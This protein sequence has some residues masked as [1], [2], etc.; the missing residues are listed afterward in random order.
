MVSTR[1]SRRSNPEP[2]QEVTAP[3]GRNTRGKKLKTKNTGTGLSISVDASSKTNI[4][5]DVDE[6]IHDPPEEE[7][8]EPEVEKES[9]DDDD[10][11]VV[12]EVK[13]VAARRDALEQLNDEETKGLKS[14]KK[15]KRK[16]R[17]PKEPVKNDDEDFDDAFF[18]ELQAARA[19][20]EVERKRKLPRG[21]HTTFRYQEED[22]SPEMS[23]NMEHNIQVV[24]L[25]NF[26]TPCQ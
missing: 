26:P 12:E 8:L 16:D 23:K 20:E 24:V 5:F 21:K 13:G 11:D 15:R 9:G 19:Q 2:P 4:V 17:R 3:K 10:D 7:T 18:E 6:V 25:G 22:S 14:K 1:R